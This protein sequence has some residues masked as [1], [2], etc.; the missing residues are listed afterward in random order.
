VIGWI[1]AKQAEFYRLSGLIRAAKA[2]GSAVWALLGP[3]PV[4]AAGAMW[5]SQ[6]M[7]IIIIIGKTELVS[8][9][10]VPVCDRAQAADRHVEGRLAG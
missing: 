7:I 9:A 2:D 6:C 1:L 3:R 4:L 8:P 5:S 10:V